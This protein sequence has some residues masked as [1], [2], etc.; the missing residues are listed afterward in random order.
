[1]KTLFCCV[2]VGFGAFQTL[3][4]IKVH[5][6]ADSGSGSLR[7]AVVQA[8]NSG[9]GTI[10]FTKVSGTIT[11]QSPLPALT[12]NITLAGPGSDQLTIQGLD[13][14]VITN[15]AGNTVTIQG[16]TLTGG[17]N[18]PSGT[19][20]NFGSLNLQDCKVSGGAPEI[21]FGGGIYNTGRVSMVNCTF[22]NCSG[23][24]GGA[25]W[26]SGSIT[27][28]GC[29]L[30]NNR[31]GAGGCIFNSGKL[32]LDHCVI[33]GNRYITSGDGGGIYN[34]CGTVVVTN[35][36]ITNNIG[37]QGGGI[38]NGGSLAVINTTIAMNRATY[39]DGPTPGGAIFND[40]GA[41]VMLV[42]TTISENT[43]LDFGGGIMNLGALW[44][45][46]C[47]IVSNQVFTVFN[48]GDEGGGIWNSGTIYTKN[49]IIA[50]NTA[51]AGP[52][53]FGVLVSQGFN[54]IQDPSGCVITGDS[55]GNLLGVD[56]LL[57]PLQDNGG[58]TFTHALLPSSPAINAGTNV[59]A[60]GT[61]QR[62]VSRPQGPGTDIGAFEV[63]YHGRK[64]AK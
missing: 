50:E 57:G 48:E 43:A 40:T 36:S 23:F 60:P 2:V 42:N 25:I 41:T 29:V 61:D 51:L 21:T 18:F 52:G 55:T 14:T 7:D 28:A 26:N 11:L 63:L 32:T 20:A 53:I 17:R 13:W 39:S 38:W 44:L 49:S 62:G 19:I 64:P 34:F 54:L 27:I 12:H 58:P 56:P 47:T 33:A 22:F 1:M 9:G 10:K 46:N 4:D 37:I 6:N 24:F 8:N 35:C 59:G 15:S 45:L 31:A 16:L 30:T 3:A 5:N